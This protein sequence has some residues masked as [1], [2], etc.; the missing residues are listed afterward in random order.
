MIRL[1][2]AAKRSSV[3][4]RLAPYYKTPAKRYEICSNMQYVAPNTVGNAH[5][6]PTR[7]HIRRS[8]RATILIAVTILLSGCYMPEDSSAAQ[9]KSGIATWYGPGFYGNTT[10]C[11]Q[12]YSTRS[13]GVA[14]NNYQC[15]TKLTIKRRNRV[16]NVTVI[17]TGNFNHSFDLSS[18]VAKALCHCNRPYTMNVNYRKGWTQ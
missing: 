18:R 5:A 1:S 16:V 11:G 8:L 9:W 10:A 12:Y 6:L 14:S 4:T 17:D 15:G 2:L 3:R 13:W 7:S